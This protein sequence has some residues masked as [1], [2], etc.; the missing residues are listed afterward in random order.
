MLESVTF[1]FTIA[2]NQKAGLCGCAIMQ[3]V[4]G[5]TAPTE[6][7]IQFRERPGWQMHPCSDLKLY[8]VRDKNE[9][10]IILSHY[11]QV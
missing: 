5:S 7:V 11:A 10:D 9:L 3:G 2:F 4:L 8:T 6:V 1:P